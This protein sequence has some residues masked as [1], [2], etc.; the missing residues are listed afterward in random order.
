MVGDGETIPYETAFLRPPVVTAQVKHR[1][2]ELTA[3]LPQ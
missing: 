1:I 2:A 3:E